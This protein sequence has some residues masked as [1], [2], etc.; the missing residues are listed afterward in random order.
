MSV[1]INGL[2]DD[3]KARREM[4]GDWA[5][6]EWWKQYGEEYIKQILAKR[7]KVEFDPDPKQE[8]FAYGGFLVDGWAE[9]ATLIEGEL[10]WSG[11]AVTKHSHFDNTG[12]PLTCFGIEGKLD[13]EFW[14]DEHHGKDGQRVWIIVKPE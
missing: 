14:I 8:R 13:A 7:L 9:I 4:V 12:E 11:Q 1:R 3:V 10:V 5:F 2:E 6:E